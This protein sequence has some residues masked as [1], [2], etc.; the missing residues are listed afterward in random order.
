[1]KVSWICVLLILRV[2]LPDDVSV[3]SEP[4]RAAGHQLQSGGEGSV[5]S[6]SNSVG[7][8]LLCV[9]AQHGHCLLRDDGSCIHLFLKHSKP[10]SFSSSFDV[11]YSHIMSY[12]PL[13]SG[14]CSQKPAP[15]PEEPASGHSHP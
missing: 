11:C 3:L 13:Q 10:N 15:Q 14:L 7:Q 5:L 8:T 12:S 1:M 6:L 2:R 4:N 9:A